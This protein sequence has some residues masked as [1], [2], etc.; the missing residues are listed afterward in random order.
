MRAHRLTHV[1]VLLAV[2]FACSQISISQSVYGNIKGMLTDISG[3]P[4]AGARVIISSVGKGTRYRTLTDGSGFYA[5]NDV[6]PDDY[7]LRIEADGFKTYQNPLVTVYADNPTMVNPKLVN[8]SAS[9]VVTGSAADVSVLKIDR[10][11]VA[12]IFSKRQVADLPLQLQNVSDLGILAPGAVPGKPTL[13]VEQNPQQGVY[14]NVNGQL[15]SGTAYQLDGTDNRDPIEGLVVINP[16]QDAVGEMK[17][18]TQNY[19]AEFGEATAGVVTA[20][21][22]SGS[23]ALHGSLFGYR[24]SGWGQASDPDLF[25]TVQQTNPNTNITTTSMVPPE[26]NDRTYKKNQFGGSIGGPIIKD[27]MFFFADYRGTRDSSGATLTL[28]VPTAQVHSTCL[29][30]AGASVQTDCNLS[31]Y[32]VGL[33]GTAVDTSNPA[34]CAATPTTPSTCLMLL[35]SQISPQTVYLLSLL[36]LPTTS[37]SIPPCLVTNNYQATGTEPFNSDNSDFRLDYAASQKLKL[38]GRYSYDSYRQDGSPAYGIAGGPGTNPDL[39]AGHARTAN[40]SLSSG[41]SYSFNSSLLTDFRFGY[42]RY[43]LDMNAPDFGTYPLLNAP[44]GDVIPGLNNAQDIYTSGMPDIQI[45]NTAPQGVAS[46]ASGPPSTTDFLDF[47]SSIA[48]G[49]SILPCNCPLRE[50]EQQFQWVN[51]WTKQ[52]G[53]HSL[54]WGAD[55][56]YIQNFRLSTSGGGTTSR[57]GRLQ[58]SD[59]TSFTSLG[60]GD[61]LVGQLDFFDRTYSD[62]TNPSAYDATEHQKRAFFYG[63]DNWRVSSRLTINYGLRWELY[64]PQTA[65]AGG[66]MLIQGDKLPSIDNATINVVG[67]SGVNQQG[68][69]QNTFKNFGPRIGFAYLAGRKTVI[70][71]GF[72]RSFDV[73]Y[74]GSI[75]GIAATQNPPIAAHFQMRNGSA[76]PTFG[77]NGTNVS[78]FSSF[79]QFQMPPSFQTV[80][81]LCVAQ[82]ANATSTFT[83]TQNC[84]PANANAPKSETPGFQ[85]VSGAALYALPA[86]LRLPTVDAWNLTLQHELTPNMYFEV[87][88]VGNKGT[89]VLTDSTGDQ[90]TN[91]VMDSTPYYD[92]NAPTLPVAQSNATPGRSCSA[93][94][95]T[96]YCIPNE[97]VNS[98]LSP[99]YFPVYYF[100]NNASDNYRSLQAKF[101]KRFSGG[102]T[103]LANYVYSK[104]LDYDSSYYAIDPSA[105][106]GPAGFDRRHTFT[107]ANTWSLP[108]GR[109][110]A[111]LKDI[112][113]VGDRV[114][115]GWSLSAITAW[116]SGLPFSP[117]YTE[118]N[119]E[120]ND[121]LGT[122]AGATPPCRPNIVGPVSITGNRNQYFTTTPDAMALVPAGAVV[123]SAPTTWPFCGLDTSG[124]PQP[125]S[126][127]GSYQR[128]GCGQIGNAGR[129]SLRGPRYFQ[130]DIALAKEIPITDR[131]RLRFRADAFNVFNKVNLGLPN[132]VVDAPIQAGAITTIAPGAI[133]RQFEFSARLQF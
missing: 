102:Y 89:H 100:G 59:N 104:V 117:T 27:R 23:N 24:Q 88:Y 2:F 20:Q 15:F 58:F 56:R 29:G 33:T 26:I 62:P 103:M 64:F 52:A 73:G 90:G 50:H 112:G 75:F 119:R 67:A 3:K 32:G 35:N 63:E 81:D 14:I 70:R 92:L 66:F 44:A 77:L 31:E 54:R 78:N 49:N 38:F 45:L 43:H 71:A 105:G 114:V 53:H 7:S 85:P 108:I 131:V 69:V 96:T 98:P 19:G 74:A 130:S 22:K 8:G 72:G 116:Y 80:E 94:T 41:F 30:P 95:G 21:T 13:S 5:A 10:T 51:N 107:M 68:N 125:G 132:S 37:C 83:T 65:N 124:N 97:F 39:F 120:C 47:G 11:D 61:F 34:G 79:T 86:K 55:I 123:G 115:G 91:A 111:V 25:T 36:P 101:S 110:R 84:D 87:A 6:S 106:Y 121:D 128:P 16:N 46:P 4:I 126:T 9:E 17:I 40:Q 18:T 48:Q 127:E 99:W 42:L 1:S 133:Q 76:D 28:T 57:V 60:L 82:P 129:N 109:G 93:V 113:T 118:G 12:T 122:A